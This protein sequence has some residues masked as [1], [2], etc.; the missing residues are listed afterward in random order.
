MLN[1]QYNRPAQKF[2]TTK[3]ERLVLHGELKNTV[4]KIV[5]FIFRGSN[6]FKVSIKEPQT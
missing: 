3:E 1:P 5:F 4:T 2:H 6:V